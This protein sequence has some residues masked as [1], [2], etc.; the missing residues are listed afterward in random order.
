MA[1]LGWSMLAFLSMESYGLD[2]VLILSPC[3]SLL[4]GN[5]NETDIKI[6]HMKEKFDV[7]L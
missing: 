5:K 7:K 3:H 2:L 1:C 6:T 4:G